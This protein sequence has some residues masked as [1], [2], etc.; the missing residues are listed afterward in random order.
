VSTPDDTDRSEA[1]QASEVGEVLSAVHQLRDEIR[2]ARRDIRSL[3]RGLT[4]LSEQVHDEHRRQFQQIEA[5]TSL[6]YALRP[7]HPLPPTRLWAASPDLLWYL[8]RTVREA[9][10]TRILECGSGVST[11]IFAYALQ[12]RGE[13]RVYALEHDE[14]YA[15]STR[16]LLRQHQLQDW[17]EVRHAP[18]SP[19]DLHGE[20]WPW[21]DTAAIPQQSFDL[22]FVDGPPGGTRDHARFPAVPLLRDRLADGGLILL[23]DHSRPDEADIGRRW[24]EHYP[25]LAAETLPHEKGTL[26]LRR[27]P[28]PAD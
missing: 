15:R 26:L 9:G 27:A 11:L 17:A 3:R 28:H 16:D 2:S 6:Y 10:R 7:R 21:Y 4:R 14:A 18:L 25:E 1:S 20:T 19:V 12:E 5:L 24:L 13:G 8:Y 23:D 22:I